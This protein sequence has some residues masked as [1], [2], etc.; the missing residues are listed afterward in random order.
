VVWEEGE[1]EG[2]D[3]TAKEAGAETEK[4]DIAKTKFAL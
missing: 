1:E 4:K 3:G 2:D